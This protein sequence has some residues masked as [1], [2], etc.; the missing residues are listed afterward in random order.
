MKT[1]IETQPHTHSQ[2]PAT[3][4][5]TLCRGD[6]YSPVL[7]SKN[8]QFHTR[9]HLR[10]R[11]THMLYICIA[12]SAGLNGFKQTKLREKMKNE[13]LLT[14]SQSLANSLQPVTHTFSSPGVDWS[15]VPCPH[16]YLKVTIFSG[17]LIQR[18][19]AN[20]RNSLN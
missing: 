8:G 10:V 18:I 12:F 19:L 11:Y 14:H 16:N 7:S 6:C 9:T 5:Q 20:C 4:K 17:Y 13:F 3:F 1:C 2:L 15:Y